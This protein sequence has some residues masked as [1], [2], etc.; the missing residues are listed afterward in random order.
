[1]LAGVTRKNRH[2]I[3][4]DVNDAVMGVGGWIKS[5]TLFSNIATTFHFALPSDRMSM[6]RERMVEAGVRLDE[7]SNAKH[8]AMPKE[9]VSRS[10]GMAASLN[11]TFIHTEPDLRRDVPRVPG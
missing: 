11:L 2:Q 3:T 6:L 10:D 9:P 8:D 1:M 7:E 4:A 5:H